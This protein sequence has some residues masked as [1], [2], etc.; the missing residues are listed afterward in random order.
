MTGRGL[1]RPQ[2]SSKRV[3]G[4]LLEA[5]LVDS[6]IAEAP[7]HPDPS[8]EIAERFGSSGEPAAEYLARALLAG[9]RRIQHS[10]PGHRGT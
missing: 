2:M 10:K 6:Y 9:R 3:L 7:R 4:D 8:D 1:V 5:R